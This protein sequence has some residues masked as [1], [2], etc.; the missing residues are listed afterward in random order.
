M[1]LV[2]APSPCL[3]RA[4]ARKRLRL[5]LAWATHRDNFVLLPLQVAACS[6]ERAFAEDLHQVGDLVGLGRQLESLCLV[7]L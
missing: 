2:G 6:F 5:A 4:R 1:L 3:W 7:V